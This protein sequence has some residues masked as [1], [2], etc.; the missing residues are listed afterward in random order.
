MKKMYVGD[1]TFIKLKGLG[2]INVAQISTVGDSTFETG[3]GME[4]HHEFKTGTA[5]LSAL[6]GVHRIG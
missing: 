1:Q 3:Y 6:G 2:W 5:F 4:Y